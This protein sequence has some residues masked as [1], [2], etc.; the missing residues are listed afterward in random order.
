MRSTAHGMLYFWN[1]LPQT[2]LQIT[3]HPNAS[4]LLKNPSLAPY[5]LLGQG[6]VQRTIEQVMWGAIVHI[7]L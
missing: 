7:S 4:E 6:N 3:P 5:L 1:L 2:S